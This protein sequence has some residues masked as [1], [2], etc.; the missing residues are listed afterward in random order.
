MH[1]L[2]TGTKVYNMLSDFIKNEINYSQF[3]RLRSGTNFVNAFILLFVEP[4]QKVPYI[5]LSKGTTN[6][7]SEYIKTI[8]SRLQI[9]L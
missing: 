3:N 9:K 1:F 2:Y 7:G 5:F 6:E 8:H 4:V